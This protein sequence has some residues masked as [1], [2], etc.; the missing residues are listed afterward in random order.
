MGQSTP[1]RAGKAIALAALALAALAAAG[2]V[3]LAPVA[4][5]EPAARAAATETV[6][7]VDDRYAPKRL[8]VAADTR[9]EWVWSKRNAN[10]HDV[11][12]DVRPKGARRF[13]SPPAKTSAKFARTLSKPGTYKILCT[14]HEG[15]RMRIDVSR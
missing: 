7:I 3:P 1:A 2:A 15:M 9:V 12:L 5:G 14:F 10:T 11:Y 4:G 8:T 13:N 6:R